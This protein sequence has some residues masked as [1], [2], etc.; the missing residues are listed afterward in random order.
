MFDLPHVIDAEPIAQFDLRQRI[1]DQS[2]LRVLVPRLRQLVLVEHAEFHV[3]PP[4][5][6]FV[7]RAPVR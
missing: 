4:G 3:V 6:G 1:L 2:M 5:L 7:S